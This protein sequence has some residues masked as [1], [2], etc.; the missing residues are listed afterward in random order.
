MITAYSFDEINNKNQ[1]RIMN[2]WVFMQILTTF[3]FFN[4]GYECLYKTISF[5]SNISRKY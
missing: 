1:K 4:E 3:N 2:L 5:K